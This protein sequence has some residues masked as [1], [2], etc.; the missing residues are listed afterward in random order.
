MDKIITP[1]STYPKVTVKWLNPALC[2]YQSLCLVYS[3][4][5]RNRQLQV[6]SKRKQTLKIGMKK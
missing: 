2:L 5:L 1:N 4:V 6:A 3:E